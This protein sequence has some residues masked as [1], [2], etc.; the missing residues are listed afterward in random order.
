M[1]ETHKNGARDASVT[2]ISHCFFNMLTPENDCRTKM[3]HKLSIDFNCK[4]KVNVR[5]N[6]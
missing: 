1:L 6:Q 2:V 5:P 4:M 3:E